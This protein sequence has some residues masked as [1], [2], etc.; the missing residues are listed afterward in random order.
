MLSICLLILYFFIL[1]L[2]LA[3]LLVA[4]RFFMLWLISKHSGDLTFNASLPLSSPPF[5]PSFLLSF[6]YQKTYSD[7]QSSPL[8]QG[9]I[10][11]FSG[12]GLEPESS[13]SGAS[14]QSIWTVSFSF[15][16]IVVLLGYCKCLIV[17]FFFFHSIETTLK[18]FSFHSADGVDHK[19]P[20]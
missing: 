11:L 14:A 6:H 19:L 8:L 18:K 7:G 10:W 17:L 9:F 3:L 15:S 5:F 16:F 12:L 20:F 4:Q 13:E 2:F 1:L